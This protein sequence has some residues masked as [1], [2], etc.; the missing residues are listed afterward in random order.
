MAFLVEDDEVIDNGVVSYTDGNSREDVLNDEISK[1]KSHSLWVEKYRPMNLKDLLGNQELKEKLALYIKNNDIPHLLLYGK[2]GG[3]KTTVAKLL[4]NTLKCDEL[5]INA[6]SENSVDTV[7]ERIQNFA[8]CA[9]LNGQK[10]IILDEFDYMSPNAQAA[11][12]NIMEK[13]SAHTRFIL[14][15]NYVEKIFEPIISRCQTI[16]MIPP[17]K[18]DV[19]V[20]VTNILTAEGVSYEPKDVVVLVNSMYPDIRKIINT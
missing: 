1:R 7:R 6:S 15:C 11:L 16:E 3:G 5:Y 4:T 10:I 12:R 17:S 19:A 9:G 8:M 2:A 18:R 13:Y 14:T 20:H